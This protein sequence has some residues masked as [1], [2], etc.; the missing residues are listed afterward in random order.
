MKKIIL[1]MAMICT[2][3]GTSFAADPCKEK[4]NEAKKLLA[5]CK[6][7]EKGSAKYKECANSYKVAKNAA[8]QACRSGGLDEK[9]MQDAIAQ[10]EKQVNHCK[11]KQNRR[12]ASALQQ[13]GHY[14]FQL[15]EKLFLDKQAQY[16]EDVAWCADRDNKPEKCANIDQFPKADHQ[17]SLG[18]FLEYI[19]KYPKEDKTPVVLY[20]AA[21]VQEASGEDDKAFHLRDRLVRNF[22]DN[23]LVPKAWLRIAEYH[24]MNR[25]F[26][27]AISAYK[28]VTGFENLTGKEAA[29]AMYHL[30][31]SYYN[32]AE[33]ETA[34]VK[35]YDYII[36]ADK[37]K[38]PNDLRAE[39]MDFMAA[40]FSD[41]EGGGVAEAEAFLKDKKVPFKDSVYYRIG[42]KNK[43]H[44]RNEEAVQSF[45]RLMSINPDYI[46]APLADIAMIEILIIQQK[47]EEAQQ[48]RYV[49]V[50]RYD[51]SSSWYKKNQKYPES[52]KNAET[53]IR[54]AM[55]DIP[56]YHHARAAKLTKEGDLEAGKK[57]YAEAIKAYEA[58]LKRYAKEPTWDE[59]KVHINLALV[60]QEMGQH[61]NAAKMFNWIVDTDT[62]RYGRRPMGSEALLKK[63]EAAYNAVLMM[64]QAREDAK[65]KK[66]GDDAKKAYSLPETKAYFAQVDKYMAKYGNNK[67]A[68]EL[69][70]NA[71][72]VHYDA[73]QYKTA[74]TV[75][76]ELRQKYPNHQYI[77]LISRMLAQSL[78]ESDQLDEALTEF[79]WLYK[80][81]HDV[82]ATKNDSMAKEIEKAI[83][84]V[85]FQKAEKA[86]KN[87]RYEEGA[88]AYLA[89][90]K[91]YPLVSF[92]DKAVFEAGVAYENAKQHDKAAETF[93]ILPKSYASSSLTIKGI[94]RA[95]SNYKKGGKPQQAATTFLFIT[96]NFPQDSMAFQAIGFA[97][98][99]YDSIPD[100]KNA[101]VTFELAY[102]RYPKHE[103][104]P[105]FLYSACLSYDEAKMTDEAIRCSKDL[106]RDY[107]K[108]TYALDAAFSIPVA[109]GNAKKWDLAAQEY[110]FFIK[111]YGND[112]KEKLI[113]AYIGAARAYMELKEEEKAVE[114]YRKTLEAY[115]KYGLQI[116]NADPGVPAEAAFFLGEYE[117]HKME[118]IVI[119]GKEKDK[120]KVIKQLVEILQKA[121]S[122]YSKSA[123]YASEKWTFR[124]TNKM[125]MLFVTM[126]AKI[127][128]QELNGKKEEEKFA[129]RIGIVQQL[130]SYYEQARPIFQKNI[131]LARD[132]GFYNKDVVEAEEGYIE[133]YY[134]GCAVFVE[135]ADA[136]ASSPL[137]DSAAIVKEYVEYEGAVKEDAI[138]MA[139]ED[140]EAYREELNTRSDGAKQLAIPQ[141]ATGI[142]ASAHYG[143]DNQW[144]AKLFELL[145][146]L[147]ENNETLNT[148]IEK[149]DPSTLFADPSYFK[150]KARLEQISKSEVMTPEEQINTYRDI[151]KDAKAEN[152][153][154][155]AEL[156]ELKKQMEPAPSTSM[157]GMDDASM[158]A[159]EPA[160]APAAP[161]KK[162]S[163]KKKGKKR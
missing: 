111:N 36:G 103:K 110:H 109:Y 25:K 69:A 74:V 156:A 42:M 75:L 40:S 62:T 31:E 160:P 150:T 60:Y 100:K 18:Y 29:L 161:A 114:D 104:T 63:E 68:A 70:Y 48:H 116:K 73:K 97:A 157:G 61:A 45:K 159:S 141:C 71:A 158:D 26:R 163:G 72:I 96:N 49:V 130:P 127:R 21:A 5:K 28:K 47:F 138:E 148:K 125:G 147:D 55:L 53:A 6:S 152:E 3:V 145:K 102:K 64:D 92:A 105:A 44:D 16:E 120:A 15:E 98:Q 99:T 51:R 106:V 19:D 143:I 113:A 108:S 9:G 38:Y 87:Q 153:K 93:M 76:R 2:L 128:E 57:Q 33:Y 124:A 151:I 131:D 83:A 137:P 17:K 67:E 80:Q 121:M 39:A 95:A 32:I 13:L 117:Y 10:W 162:A 132:Q 140:L 7:M 23:G 41:L 59:Y 139:H 115:D 34:A 94:L 8:A 50:K 90:V 119:K 14:Q 129:E 136:F 123:T 1:A 126:A 84:A 24:F 27:D 107:P 22:P 118:P 12:C 52:V 144:T 81:Y 88:V 54:G 122:Q 43:D 82:K 30:A 146:S 58:F 35:Y 91:R 79:E 101:A 20:Q 86:V 46:D 134:Q 112:D 77:L 142:K 135:V 149:F 155:K 65:K 133:M 154:L 66:A 56:Q 37:G 85:L 78:L 11:G 4:T 89:L